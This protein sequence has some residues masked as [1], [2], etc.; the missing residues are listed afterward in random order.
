MHVYSY[1]GSQ[2]LITYF[3]CKLIWAIS[4]SIERRARL[5]E[6]PVAFL[7][8]YKLAIRHQS[9]VMTAPPL[10]LD[11]HWKADIEPFTLLSTM[12]CSESEKLPDKVNCFQW[13][14]ENKFWLW[15][16]L[17]QLYKNDS[18]ADTKITLVPAGM[19]DWYWAFVKLHY[20]QSCFK[21]WMIFILVMIKEILKEI[22]CHFMFSSIFELSSL[23][24]NCTMF[25]TMSQ[26]SMYQGL[27][28]I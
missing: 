22:L 19:K 2:Q 21:R 14:Q 10:N 28:S 1:F 24:M 12:I 16:L 18:W 15:S 23:H 11:L 6:C 3:H 17:C 27:L 5:I 9:D 26:N 7:L 13:N 8:R 20:R 4:F 25:K